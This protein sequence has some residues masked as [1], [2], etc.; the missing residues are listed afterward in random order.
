MPRYSAAGVQKFAF[1]VPAG[2]PNTME[3]GGT[4]TVDGPA[5]F[6][7]AWFAQRPNALEWFQKE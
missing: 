5:I 6:P 3:A 7:T 1:L 4:E 2:A